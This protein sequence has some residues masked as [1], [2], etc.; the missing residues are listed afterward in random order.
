MDMDWPENTRFSFGRFEV[1]L[2]EEL[3][4]WVIVVGGRVFGDL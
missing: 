4:S 3:N 1:W 2:D